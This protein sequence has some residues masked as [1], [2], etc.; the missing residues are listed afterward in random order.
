MPGPVGQHPAVHVLGLRHPLGGAAQPVRRLLGVGLD[1][2]ALVETEPEIEHGDQVAG[3]GGLLEPMRD[4]CRILRTAGAVEH[5]IG[6]IDL[7][8]RVAG[9]TGDAQPAGCLVGIRRHPGAGQIQ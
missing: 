8:G 3:G 7:R 5:E 6:E 1:T 2:D 9:F 4:P